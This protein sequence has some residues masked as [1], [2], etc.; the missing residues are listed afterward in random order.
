MDGSGVV[1]QFSSGCP[2]PDLLGWVGVLLL[3]WSEPMPIWTAPVCASE[4]SALV[5]GVLYKALHDGSDAASRPQSGTGTVV[6]M[7]AVC[8]DTFVWGGT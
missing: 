4:L 7:S 3:P 8:R 6:Q 1:T 2:W 5:S